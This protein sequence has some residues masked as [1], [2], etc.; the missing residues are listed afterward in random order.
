M[1]PQSILFA[2]ILPNNINLTKFKSRG[3]KIFHR[4]YLFWSK[5]FSY[6]SKINF[7]QHL[8]YLHYFCVMTIEYNNVKQCLSFYSLNKKNT[9]FI[10]KQRQH[11]P[12]RN[13][14]LSIKHNAI[15]W[16]HWSV[17]G[18][19]FIT[20]VRPHTFPLSSP[21]QRGQWFHW[22]LQNVCRQEA[23]TLTVVW[24]WQRWQWSA[25]WFHTPRQLYL[26][27]WLFLMHPWRQLIVQLHWHFVP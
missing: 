27:S 2:Q 23:D 7:V 25:K 12:S 5:K 9:F 19:A 14:A 20:C 26:A 16:H 17:N 4:L 21:F 13:L 22:R 18:R 15:Y 3:S 24:L 10:V 1:S 8:Y 6:K 11:Y